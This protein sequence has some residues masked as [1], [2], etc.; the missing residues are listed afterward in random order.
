MQNSEIY[1]SNNDN[2]NDDDNNKI[3]III[4]NKVDYG[5]LL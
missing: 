3:T 1:T 5:T 2:G 4:T